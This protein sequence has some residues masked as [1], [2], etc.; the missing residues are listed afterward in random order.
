[1]HKRFLALSQFIAEDR[2]A[3]SRGL[4]G[5]LLIVCVD[6]VWPTL[7]QSS[8]DLADAICEFFRVISSIILNKGKEHAAK[9]PSL[10]Q[11]WH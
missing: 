5:D 3:L 9:I 10:L 6:H 7:Q 1:M 4:V 2:G 8:R 11:V